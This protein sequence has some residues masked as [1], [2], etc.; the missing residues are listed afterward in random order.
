MEL[1]VVILLGIGFVSLGFWVWFEMSIS[2]DRTQFLEQ[3]LFEFSRRLNKLEKDAV[4]VT[5][6][7]KPEYYGMRTTPQDVDKILN[8]NIGDQMILDEWQKKFEKRNGGP[9]IEGNVKSTSKEDTG[10]TQGP[11]PPPIKKRKPKTVKQWEEEID[12]GGH[13]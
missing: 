4:K 10:T 7:G 13:E 1:F 9:L 6:T 12:L 11:P 5:F 3:K 2:N 8:R